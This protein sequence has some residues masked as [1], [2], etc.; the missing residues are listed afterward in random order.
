[1]RQLV[2]Q[3]LYFQHDITQYHKHDFTPQI[4]GWKIFQNVFSEPKEIWLLGHYRADHSSF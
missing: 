3:T 4:S 2:E 1:M